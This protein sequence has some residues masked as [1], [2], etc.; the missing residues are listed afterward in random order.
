[1]SFVIKVKGLER[2]NGDC[3][4]TGGHANRSLQEDV[5]IKVTGGRMGLIA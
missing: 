4:Q 3:V 2:D 1:M 5:S